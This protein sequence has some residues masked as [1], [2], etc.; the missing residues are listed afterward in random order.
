MTNAQIK[1]HLSMPDR[2]VVITQCCERPNQLQAWRIFRNQ[3]LCLLLVALHWMHSCNTGCMLSS[4]TS[5][6]GSGIGGYADHRKDD[7][8]VR[9]EKKIHKRKANTEA[10]QSVESR[11]LDDTPFLT[12]NEDDKQI[13]LED[14]E[15]FPAKFIGW[16]NLRIPWLRNLFH[17]V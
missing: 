16:D 3:Y 13:T 14:L 17:D 5:H 10:K 11:P 12:K 7:Y 4:D 2:G 1:Y 9:D 8:G 15:I 6:R